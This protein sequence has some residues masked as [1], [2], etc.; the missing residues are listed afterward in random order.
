LVRASW[1]FLE[2]IGEIPLPYLAPGGIGYFAVSDAA[3][4]RAVDILFAEVAI[5]REVKLKAWFP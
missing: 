3:A 5:H 2:S 1:A 4:L